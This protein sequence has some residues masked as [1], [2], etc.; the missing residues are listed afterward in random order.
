M[1]LNAG[2]MAI[3]ELDIASGDLSRSAELNRLLGYPPDAHPTPDEIRAANHPGDAERMRELWRQSVARGEKRF[4]VEYR[5][6]L[7]DGAIRWLWLRVETIADDAGA[8]VRLI[9]VVM[10]ITARKEAEDRADLLAREVDHRA[11]NLL[12]VVQ[13][14]V[15]LSRAADVEALR[16]TISS[17][18]QALARVNRRSAQSGW[19]P[20]PLERLIA[21]ELAPYDIGGK[22]DV[23][24]K[25]PTS[26]W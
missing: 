16:E 11:N 1:A 20:E 3:W 18:V 6:I 25:A 17:R 12:A 15:G 10:D 7:P 22:L 21:E 24:F 26:S 4:E 8:P 9:G 5:R 14:I 2:Q 23:S 19:T 13:G